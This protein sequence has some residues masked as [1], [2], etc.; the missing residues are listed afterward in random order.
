M[1]YRADEYCAAWRAAMTF[2]DMNRIDLDADE[3]E[4]C[5]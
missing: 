2:L 5:R 3:E 1:H 4:F